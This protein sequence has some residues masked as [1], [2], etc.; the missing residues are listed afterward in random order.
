MCAISYSLERHP[1]G[2]NFPLYFPFSLFSKCCL[3]TAVTFDLRYLLPSCFVNYMSLIYSINHLVF[4]SVSTF[5]ALD[6]PNGSL[7]IQLCTCSLQNQGY[8]SLFLYLCMLI[9]PFL[10]FCCSP[11]LPHLNLPYMLFILH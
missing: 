2:M 10:L 4:L 7:D 6:C 3:V 9:R 8:I 5:L 1:M 11:K